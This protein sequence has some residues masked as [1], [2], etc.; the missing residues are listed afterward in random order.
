MW[1]FFRFPFALL[2][3]AEFG[4]GTKDEELSIWFYMPA[5]T[6]IQNSRHFNYK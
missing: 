5:L 4:S 6:Q 3:E 1:T 2:D